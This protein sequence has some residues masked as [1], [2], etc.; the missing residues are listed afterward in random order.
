MN[1]FDQ[2]VKHRLKA[3]YHIRYADDFVVLSRDKSWLEELLFRMGDFLEEKLKLSLHPNKV[4]IKTLSSGVDFLGWVHFPYHRVLRTTTKR[5]MLKKLWQNSK[6]EVVASYLG[7][8]SH[9]NTHKIK[10]MILFGHENTE[11]DR[12]S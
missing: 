8:L 5:R 7:L 9:G 3:K 2:F 6:T 11:D 4:F 12:K 1:E 10:K